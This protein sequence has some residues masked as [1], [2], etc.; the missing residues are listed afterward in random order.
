MNAEDISGFPQKSWQGGQSGSPTQSQVQQQMNLSSANFQYNNISHNISNEYIESPTYQG[1]NNG[2][3]QQQKQTSMQNLNSSTSPLLFSNLPP[4]QQQQIHE[5]QTQQKRYQQQQHFHAQQNLGQIYSQQDVFINPQQPEQLLNHPMSKYDE[6]DT[7][8]TSFQ[9]SRPVIQKVP[10]ETQ[11]DWKLLQSEKDSLL[12]LAG[13]TDETTACEPSISADGRSSMKSEIT[14][15]KQIQ[16]TYGNIQN[17]IL[18]QQGDVDDSEKVK[19]RSITGTNK[20]SSASLHNEAF[21]DIQHQIN[22]QA[23]GVTT[24][25]TASSFMPAPSDSMRNIQTANLQIQGRQIQPQQQQTQQQTQSLAP[26]NRLQQ[27]QQQN[28]GYQ[29]NMPQNRVPSKPQALSAHSSHVN[30]PYPETFSNT[31]LQNAVNYSSSQQLPIR[32]L[33]QSYPPN[34]KMPS[35]FSQGQNFQPVME[36]RKLSPSN[37][38]YQQQR[39]STQYLPNSY[40]G[41]GLPSF[42]PQQEI[43]LYMQQRPNQSFLPNHIS[44]PYLPPSASQPLPQPPRLSEEVKRNLSNI[45][46]VR[47]LKF[48]D[49]CTCR[50]EKPNHMYLKQVVADFFS[51]NA[52]IN[53]CLKLGNESRNYTVSYA[54]IPMIHCKFLLDVRMFEFNQKF[55]TASVLPDLSTIIN[56]D[57]FSFK[58]VFKDGSYSHHFGSISCQMNKNLKMESLDIVID[59]IVQGIEMNAL[60]TFCNKF[61]IQN[62]IPP[63]IAQIKENFKCISNVT[64]F[65]VTE[66]LLRLMQ[67]SDVMTMS[68]P[69]VEFFVDSHATSVLEALESFNKVNFAEYEKLKSMTNN[70]AG[71]PSDVP[72]Q[73]EFQQIPLKRVRSYQEGMEFQQALNSGHYYTPE[74]NYGIHQRATAPQVVNKAPNR[75]FKLQ[76]PPLPKANQNMEM[77]KATPN[78]DPFITSNNLKLELK[79]LS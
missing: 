42:S 9:N 60:E 23:K 64:K 35:S 53:Y 74:S 30:T 67:I 19:G 1:N 44:Q 8:N 14:Q 36:R 63:T 7:A 17:N 68:K 34:A 46:T 49:L 52:K 55:L 66:E 11:S 21:L 33:S 45:A 27:S 75:K 24:C 6:S 5:Q 71:M 78:T 77:S 18:K 13:M 38:P 39:P 29:G 48:S 28:L 76:A 72:L 43:P 65:G 16:A 62:K 56:T 3:H 15:L 50:H 2:I 25:E 57:N 54:L 70:F 47:F 32:P 59:Y 31:P 10:D 12:L 26:S 20:M 79:D 4:Q 69:L 37:P 73:Q 40:N 22:G 58:R 51:E 61:L 41:Q